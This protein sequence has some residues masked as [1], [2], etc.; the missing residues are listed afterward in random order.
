VSMRSFEIWLVSFV[1]VLGCARAEPQRSAE[2]SPPVRAVP[3][4]PAVQ[5]VTS[6][7]AEL[8]KLGP[9]VPESEHHHVTPPPK[10]PLKTVGVIGEELEGDVSHFK[11]LSIRPCKDSKL[12][13]AGSGGAPNPAARNVVAAEVEIVAKKKLTVNPR[14]LALGKGGITF[15]ASVDPKRELEGCT[16]LL[17]LAWL[18]PNE[19]AK[20]FVLFDLPAWGPGSNVNELHLV[21]HPARFGGSAQVYVKLAGG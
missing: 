12:P 4:K 1:L 2:K 11:L 15:S 6:P 21:Y 3:A 10:A 8:G 20:G 9:V 19:S 7:A 16:P 17:K 18:R 5:N 13:P 14:D